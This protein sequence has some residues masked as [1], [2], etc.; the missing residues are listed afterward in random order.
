MLDQIQL[1]SPCLEL[2]IVQTQL[3]AP[4]LKVQSPRNLEHKWVSLIDIII[5]LVNKTKPCSKQVFLMP[6]YQTKLRNG[7]TNISIIELRCN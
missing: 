6:K 7:N 1:Q 2:Q 4:Q 5:I 3:Y